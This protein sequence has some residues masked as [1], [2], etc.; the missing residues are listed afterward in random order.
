MI[1]LKPCSAVPFPEKLF[2]QYEVGERMLK[3]NV[4]LS[5][6][7]DIMLQFIAEHDEP[8]FSSSKSRR[9]K[10][11]RRLPQRARL[12]ICTTTSTTSMDAPKTKRARC[13]TC[14]VS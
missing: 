7:R 13:W 2:E 1:E 5:K 12:G 9:V 3:A 6:V 11:T 14:S 8:S 10:R 4:S